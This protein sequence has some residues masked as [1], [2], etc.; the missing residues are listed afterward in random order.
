MYIFWQVASVSAIV[1]SIIFS[2][3][4]NPH[5]SMLCV[6]WAVFFK[7]GAVEA[8]VMKGKEDAHIMGRS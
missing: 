8:L 2:F 7:V 3:L 4:D 5:T 1:L 6:I